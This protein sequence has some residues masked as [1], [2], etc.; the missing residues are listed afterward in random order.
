MLRSIGAVIA[1]FAAMAIVVVVGVAAAARMFIPGDAPSAGSGSAMP[2]LTSSY[3]VA[4]IAV[5]VIAAVLGG[6]LTA[7]IGLRAP[8]AHGMALGIL[9]VVMGI[10]TALGSPNDGQPGWYRVALPLLGLTGV[11][12]GAT[13]AAGLMRSAP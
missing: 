6:Y 8:M 4:N 12:L 2:Q 10:A 11:L 7:R 1:G 3:M 5:S 13:L 9:V